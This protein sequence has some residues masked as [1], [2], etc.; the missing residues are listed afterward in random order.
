MK[1]EISQQ[2]VLACKK[3]FSEALNEALKLEA[4]D[5]SSLKLGNDAHDAY[6]LALW[7]HLPPAK[8]LP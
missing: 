5:N 7:E 3:T 1:L 4:V 8:R 2:L 6:V